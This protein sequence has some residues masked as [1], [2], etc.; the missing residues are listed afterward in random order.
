MAD[1]SALIKPYRSISNWYHDIG[2]II[3]Q[4][5]RILHKLAFKNVFVFMTV[6][7]LFFI[8]I[9]LCL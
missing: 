4:L 3:I 1:V 9:R 5:Y 6:T 8:L 7:A 2:T